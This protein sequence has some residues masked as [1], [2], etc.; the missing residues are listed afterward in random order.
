MQTKHKAS[1]LI[2]SF[3]STLNKNR[4]FSQ[5]LMVGK[6]FEPCFPSPGALLFFPSFE[7]QLIKGRQQTIILLRPG[8]RESSLKTLQAAAV[9]SLTWDPVADKRRE[10]KPQLSL[11]WSLVRRLSSTVGM[12]LWLQKMEVASSGTQSL[13]C[14]LKKN[15]INTTTLVTFPAC[16]KT[17]KSN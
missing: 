2:P 16:Y 12:K 17:D 7:G 3:F 10:W 6:T 13:C 9:Q 1:P 15:S 8:A 5:K 14:I 11:L 4:V